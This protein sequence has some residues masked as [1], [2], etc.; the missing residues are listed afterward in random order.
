MPHI[1][2]TYDDSYDSD[3]HPD[4]IMHFEFLRYAGMQTTDSMREFANKQNKVSNSISHEEVGWDA[5]EV[6]RL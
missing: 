1:K 6:V 5:G 4:P 2:C 3:R